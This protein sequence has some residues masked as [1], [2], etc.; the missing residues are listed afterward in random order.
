MNSY[1]F[2]DPL[3]K[4]IIEK[5]LIQ[6]FETKNDK[7]LFRY[8]SYIEDSLPVEDREIEDED[9]DLFLE[10]VD[11][12]IQYKNHRLVKKFMKSKIFQ[13][14]F[15]SNINI[16][17]LKNIHQIKPVTFYQSEDVTP[18]QNPTFQTPT[19]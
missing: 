18:I 5:R 11:I 2:S 1:F 19:K 6:A 16:A 7:L 15:I 8:L 14:H 17:A 13:K 10:F 12:L 9:K 4:N 3:V